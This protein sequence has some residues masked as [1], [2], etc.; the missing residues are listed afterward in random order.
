[1]REYG[2][3][4]FGVRLLR[5]RGDGRG[6][7]QGQQG[8]DRATHGTSFTSTDR[9]T[10][11]ERLVARCPAGATSGGTEATL[12][13]GDQPVNVRRAR[14]GAMEGQLVRNVLLFGRVLRG[15]GLDVSPGR[16]TDLVEALQHVSVGKKAD[17]YHAARCL[18]VRRREELPV[19]D[20]AFE[21]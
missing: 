19:F 18:L 13:P 11:G 12:R 3:R 17:F 2:G 8:Q 1:D 16:M 15:L 6:R 4:C 5:D 10:R 7:E 21:V 14:L 9:G 20:E